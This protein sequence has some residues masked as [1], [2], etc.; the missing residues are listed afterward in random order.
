MQDDGDAWLLP[1]KAALLRGLLVG[2]VLLLPG[3]VVQIGFAASGPLLGEAAFDLAIGLFVVAPAAFVERLALTRPHPRL[4]RRVAIVVAG[5]LASF[6]ATA[7]FLQSLYAS[8]V[9]RTG[10]LDAGFAE[11]TRGA[12][13]VVVLEDLLGLFAC[14]G[15][16]VAVTTAGRT[17]GLTTRVV[18]LRS[19][20]ATVALGPLVLLATGLRGPGLAVSTIM[21]TVL[22]VVLP[23]VAS[24]ADRLALRRG[25]DDDGR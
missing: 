5:A 13:L 23:P 1:A 3:L 17:A 8:A 7:A 21:L 16:V 25:A 20:V 19:V 11:V 24:L 6:G 22:A 4:E 10:S 9:L 2:L 12:G 14:V 18:A 15:L